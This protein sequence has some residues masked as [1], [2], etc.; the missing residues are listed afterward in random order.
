MSA[1]RS[2]GAQ[3]VWARTKRGKAM[4]VDAQHTPDGTIALVEDPHSGEL[5][6][7]VVGKPTPMAFVDG[8]WVEPRR[9][10][11]HFETCPDADAHRKPRGGAR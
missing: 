9:Y 5:T 1:C 11:S 4:P 7:H 2:C 10:T 6:A 8:V 3:I